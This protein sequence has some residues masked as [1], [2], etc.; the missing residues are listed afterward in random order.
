MVMPHVEECHARSGNEPQCSSA[1][2]LSEKRSGNG[3][4]D[5]PDLKDTVLN[6]TNVRH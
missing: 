3:D 1:E 2:T 5:V 4:S 6:N